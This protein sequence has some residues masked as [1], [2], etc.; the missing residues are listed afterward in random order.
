MP[1]VRGSNPLGTPTIKTSQLSL[2]IEVCVCRLG[3]TNFHMYD[4]YFGNNLYDYGIYMT[5]LGIFVAMQ[6]T[7][8]VSQ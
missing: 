4:S 1:K 3:C 2:I 6:M 5:K 7:K 8:K